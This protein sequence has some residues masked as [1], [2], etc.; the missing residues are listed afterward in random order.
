MKQNFCDITLCDRKPC[1]NGF[2]M[3]A[4]S[5]SDFGTDFC[6]ECAEVPRVGLCERDFISLINF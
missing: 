2:Q 4:Y 5:D 3:A 6:V 1:T